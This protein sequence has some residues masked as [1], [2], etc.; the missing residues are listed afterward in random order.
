MLSSFSDSLND[1]RNFK[2]YVLLFSSI[3]ESYSRVGF[4]FDSGR[5]GAVSF[6][7]KTKFLDFLNP[8][9]PTEIWKLNVRAF[10]EIFEQSTATIKLL[11]IP[12]VGKTTSLLKNQMHIFLEC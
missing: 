2:S 7:N 8:V 5:R 12:V 4:G 1:A 6:R 11:P 3:E 9:S 10:S